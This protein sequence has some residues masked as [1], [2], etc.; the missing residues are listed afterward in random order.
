MEWHRGDVERDLR[1]CV[2]QVGSF[3]FAGEKIIPINKNLEHKSDAVLAN[4][5]PHSPKYRINQEK[6]ES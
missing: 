2:K 4:I 3:R 1:G 6:V 5:S